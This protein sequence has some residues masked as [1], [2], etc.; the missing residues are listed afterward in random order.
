MKR[1]PQSE[2]KVAASVQHNETA[3]VGIHVYIQA[4]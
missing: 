1:K 3:L 2:K 4:L